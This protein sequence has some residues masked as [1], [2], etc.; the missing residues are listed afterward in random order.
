MSA[1]AVQATQFSFEAHQ[2][3]VTCIDLTESSVISGSNDG[4]IRIWDFGLTP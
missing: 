3:A 1:E 2:D 4:T